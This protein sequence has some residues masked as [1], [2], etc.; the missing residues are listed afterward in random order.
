M[1]RIDFEQQKQSALGA[2]ELAG[3]AV[4]EIKSA[5][6]AW[7]DESSDVFDSTAMQEKIDMVKTLLDKVGDAA[8]RT[9]WSSSGTDLSFEDWSHKQGCLELANPTSKRHR[10]IVFTDFV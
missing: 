2:I 1:R 4:S 3:E 7:H 9:R 6:G 10:E 5:L 8:K